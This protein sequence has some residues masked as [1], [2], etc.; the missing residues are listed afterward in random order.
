MAAVWLTIAALA[1][2][3]IQCERWSIS[4]A[5]KRAAVGGLLTKAHEVLSRGDAGTGIMVGKG[6]LARELT[7]RDLLLGRRA[8]KIVTVAAGTCLAVTAAAALFI[9]V[10]VPLGTFINLGANGDRM[11]IIPALLPAVG[12]SAALFTP[13]RKPDAGHM[14]KGSRYC[15]YIT[16]PLMLVWALYLQLVMFL[17]ALR[18]AGVLYF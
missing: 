12:V 15:L 5:R 2:A 10:R 14:G 18:T 8:A 4:R 6:T 1:A 11:H 13:G 9:W 16:A 3:G 17:G 7:E